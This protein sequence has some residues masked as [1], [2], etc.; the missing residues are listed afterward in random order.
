M[1]LRNHITSLENIFVSEVSIIYYFT[2]VLNK[3]VLKKVLEKLFWR[4]NTLQTAQRVDILYISDNLVI[5]LLFCTIL[6]ILSLRLIFRYFS[7]KYKK[8]GKYQSFCSQNCV[9]TDAYAKYM[10]QK[11]KRKKKT[12]T[13]NIVKLSKFCGVDCLTSTKLAICQRV[14]S[15]LVPNYLE[16]KSK[17]CCFI[18]V[19][20]NSYLSLKF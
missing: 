14:N 7:A 6:P 11:F 15:S 17:A 9:T 8:L 19:V 18:K 12:Y 4:T 2:W 16:M 10:C 13:E 5:R 20:F 1:P 3:T